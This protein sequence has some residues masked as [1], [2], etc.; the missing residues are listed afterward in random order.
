MGPDSA[1]QTGFQYRP[2]ERIVQLN[3]YLTFNGDC[4]AAFEFYE[5]ALGGKLEAMMT[6]AGTPAEAHMPPE[7]R[8]K[9]LHARL[10]VGNS[11]LMGSDAPPDH[12]QKPQGFSVNIG[13]TDPQEADRVFQ[14]LAEGGKLSMPIQQTFWARRFGMLTDRFGVPWMVNCE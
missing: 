8:D 1:G 9:I 11:V 3:S 14:A 2:K 4:K 5:K 6:H 13:I 7:W 10:A 12:Y